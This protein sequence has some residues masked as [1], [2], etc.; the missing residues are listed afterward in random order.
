[1]RDDEEPRLGAFQHC[2][3][4]VAEALDVMI[5][6]RCVDFVEDADRRRIGEEHREDQRQGGECLLATRQQRQHRRL[7]AR[8]IGDDF[9]PGFQRIVRFDQL[10]FRL[11]AVEQRGE[12][13]AEFL[14]HRFEGIEQPLAA[15]AVEA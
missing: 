10:Q 15:L 9:E 7:L 5:V 1:M 13:L 14:V 8:R 12:Q 3:Q 6:K 11:A 2:F 4:Q